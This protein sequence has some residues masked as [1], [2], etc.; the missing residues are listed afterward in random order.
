MKKI[1]FLLTIVTILFASC[2][3][4]E[5]VYS[6]PKDAAL[7]VSI[8]PASLLSKMGASND[9]QHIENALLQQTPSEHQELVKKLL[10]D[11]TYCGL[12][13]DQR[14]YNGVVIKNEYEI[15]NV[16]AL[17]VNDKEQLKSLLLEL[18]NSVNIET[19]NDS[20]VMTPEDDFTIIFNEK[21]CLIVVGEDINTKTLA[22]Q[23]IDQTKE[24][25][26]ASMKQFND[27]E[28]KNQD[29]HILATLTP[30]LMNIAK[31]SYEF[32]EVAEMISS[33]ISISSFNNLSLLSTLNFEE[34][35]IISKISSYTDNK[36]LLQYISDNSYLDK[37]L[38]DKH[39]KYI[40]ENNIALIATSLKGNQLLSTLTPDQM[41]MLETAMEGYYSEFK[42]ILEN[43][44]G[45]MTL[46]LNDTESFS[47]FAHIK[48][49]TESQQNLK[50]IINSLQ[51]EMYIDIQRPKENQYKIND[52]IYFGITNKMLYAST[53]NP[54][55]LDSSIEDN[56]I[57]NDIDD[58][59]AYAYLNIENLLSNKE[60]QYELDLEP[61]IANMI[62]NIFHYTKLT[63]KDQN[64][65]TLEI[66]MKDQ[67]KNAL[68]TIYD[69]IKIYF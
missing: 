19:F 65:V 38:D 3:K 10:Q 17:A 34:G 44:D 64:E 45:T 7:T 24:N 40:P 28:G 67:N 43:I 55:E 49:E 15:Y 62:K 47:A 30:S 68:Q 61:T 35:K 66:A 31:D 41:Y 14:I 6:I 48:K 12:K 60:I 63:C 9:L 69:T 58:Y 59:Y 26:I 5:H 54:K 50:T 36:E 22:I 27:I 52:M 29:I 37:K 32:Q 42:S 13:L 18:D 53:A 1:I 4:N 11:P 33:E 8:D 57:V 2:S 51:D 25:S 39:L 23:L 46:A 56:P 21:R 20:Y 16:L